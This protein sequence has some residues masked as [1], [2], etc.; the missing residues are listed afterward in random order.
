MLGGSIFDN[1]PFFVGHREHMRQMGQMFMDPFAGFGG[2]M[3][4]LPEPSMA[5]RRRQQQQAQNMQ[6]AERSMIMDP[7]AHF[8]S[9]FS[10]MRSM[11]SDMHR[12]FDQVS[13]NP[14]AHVYQQ[15]SFMSYSNTGNG[16]PQI[17][18]AT[19]SSRQAPGG[20]KETRKAV[21]DSK[22]GVEKVYVGH[23]LNDR[24]HIIE[25]SRNNKTG[26]QNENQEYV[27][28]DEEELQPFDQEYQEKWRTSMGQRGLEHRR[29]GDKPQRALSETPYHRS[30]HA[31]LPEP[32][33][34]RKPSSSKRE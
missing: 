23:H 31:A 20:V 3:L 16:A 17:Y 8:D 28:L 5:D 32:T 9:M 12:S 25:K 26:E 6:V 4:A 7:F 11:M 2:G 29:R 33:R 24:A 30:R 1:D 34:S 19:S 15:Q 14:N 18:Q 21:R 27:N 13:N 22:S 10:N